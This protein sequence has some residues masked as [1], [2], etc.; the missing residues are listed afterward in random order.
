MARRSRRSGRS[1]DDEA[2]PVPIS[3]QTLREAAGLF[4]YL[5]P[6]KL[7]F[8]AALAC[9]LLSS[10]CSLA[11]PFIM[12]RLVDVTMASQAGTAFAPD[13]GTPATPPSLNLAAL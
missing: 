4:G 5:L 11:L 3:R 10:L 13:A 12:G 8:L 6:Y 7:K 2:Q 9:L 1:S